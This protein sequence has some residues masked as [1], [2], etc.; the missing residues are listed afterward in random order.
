MKVLITG[1]NGFIGKN[2]LQFLYERP[3]IQVVTFTRSNLFSELP[4]LLSG[5]SFVFHLA[6]VNRTDD[7]SDFKIGNSDLTSKLLGSVLSEMKISGQKIPIVFTSSTQALSN[8]PYGVS[9]LLAEDI[10]S[11]FSSL[12]HVPVYIFRLPNVFGKWCRPNY[13]SVVATF[14]HNISH[15]LPIHVHDHSA[16][17]TLVHVDQIIA[18]F[19]SLLDRVDHPFSSNCFISGL[20]EFRTTVGDLSTTI[21]TF[22]ESRTSLLIDYV[23]VGFIRALYSTYM[24]YLPPAS[25]SYKVPM[26]SDVRGVF[27]EMLKTPD[28]GQFSFFTAHPGVTRGGHYHHT[29]TEKFLVISGFA[30]F[31]FRHIQTGESYLLDTSGDCFEIVESIPGWAHDISNIGESEL[32][33]MLWANEIFDM[34]RPDTFSFPL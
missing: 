6:G 9:K 30:R 24:S 12:H 28:S 26:H 16:P 21:K 22:R 14:C 18:N 10:L 33:V 31:H 17:I 19:L 11:K 25:F 4:S 8:N 15:D 13:N 23:G 27:V 29:K 2:L 32:V 34:D 20:P 7:P 3:D 5:V 1:S